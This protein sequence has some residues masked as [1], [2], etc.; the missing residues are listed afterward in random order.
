[1]IILRCISYLFCTNTV[2]TMKQNVPIQPFAF[3]THTLSEKASS[4]RFVC[5]RKEKTIGKISGVMSCCAMI[6]CSISL[7]TL[8]EA[9]EYALDIALDI[10][11]TNLAKPKQT[12]YVY[13]HDSRSPIF[14]RLDQ[15]TF[16]RS[17][18]R[19]CSYLHV[20]RGWIY[21][22]WGLQSA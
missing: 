7:G 13:I 18:V 10:I 8:K 6:S 21:I 9:Q 15:V 20:V 5:R 14:A 11:S 17:D 3:E 4:S 16:E 22:V 19:K 2:G 12:L 1:M